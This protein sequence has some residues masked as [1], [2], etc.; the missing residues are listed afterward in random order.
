[1]LNEHPDIYCGYESEL[2]AGLMYIFNADRIEHKDPLIY[3]IWNGAPNFTTKNNLRKISELYRKS[4]SDK[5]I[6]GDKVIRSYYNPTIIESYAKIFPGI[7]IILSWRN[8]LDQLSSYIERL[9]PSFKPDKEVNI[10]NMLEYI[11]EIIKLKDFY[12]SSLI[13]FTLPFYQCIEKDNFYK[14]YGNF[15]NYLGVSVGKN[16][17]ED[18][19]GRC[20]HYK[21][22]ERWKNDKNVI[23]LVNFLEK[24]DTILLNRCMEEL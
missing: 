19:W 1:M 23:E 16:Y 10:E 7:K 12:T 2:I 14:L 22:Q 18:Q 8:C 11:K 6:F 17:M 3:R 5:K 13:S 9:W 24:N 15:M 21:V 4:I 20:V